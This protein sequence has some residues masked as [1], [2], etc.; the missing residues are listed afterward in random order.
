MKF[1]AEHALKLTPKY[2]YTD[3]EPPP[4]WRPYELGYAP[5][6]LAV[7]SPDKGWAIETDEEGGTGR[8][9]TKYA[10]PGVI[11]KF[12]DHWATR[13]DAREYAN[14]DIV[15][16]RALD[17]HFGCP[18]PGDN[19]STLTCM[20]AAVRWHGFT[21]NREGIE[22]LKA[23]AVATVAAS[24]VN[25][26]KPSE[27]RAY[28]MAAMDGTEHLIIDESTKKANLEAISKWGIGKL[29]SNCRGKGYLK[30]ENDTCPQ[31]KGVCYVGEPEPCSKCE[32]RDPQCVRCGGT[33]LL[34]VGKHP[35]AV[36]ARK[37]LA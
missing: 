28:V 3:V 23:K 14:D 8:K 33:G 1:L 17:Q 24:P 35:A 36:R 22:S 34:K 7:A 12:I 11:R 10:W 31:C 37:F 16:T 2:H 4:A 20:V 21:I 19:D 13:T 9:V 25:I 15:Y 27:V 30:D 29:C 32:G 26:N 18:E 6:A 5:T